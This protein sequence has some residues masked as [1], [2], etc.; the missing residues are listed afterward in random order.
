MNIILVY[1]FKW[2]QLCHE[3]Q[4]VE[5]DIA[6]TDFSQTPHTYTHLGGTPTFMD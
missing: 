5:G 2:T 6:F 1:G 4:V 3:T